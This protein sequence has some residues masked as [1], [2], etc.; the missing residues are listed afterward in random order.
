MY[1]NFY[2]TSKSKY[3]SER[4][5]CDG[6]KFDSKRECNRYIELRNLERLGE[7]R[8]LQLQVKY[9]LAKVIGGTDYMVRTP[10]GRCMSYFADFVYYD[11]RRKKQVVEDVKGFDTKVSAIKRAIVKMFYDIDVEIY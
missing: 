3:K 2:N 1:G 10:T 8:D 6:I 5:Q 11:K 4:V 9:P 7:I